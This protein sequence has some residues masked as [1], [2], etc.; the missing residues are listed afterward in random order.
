MERSEMQNDSKKKCCIQRLFRKKG[1]FGR[2]THVVNGG[3]V[4]L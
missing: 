2:V 1:A 4:L 3:D